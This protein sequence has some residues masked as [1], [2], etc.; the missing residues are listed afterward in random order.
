MN[1]NRYG[2]PPEIESSAGRFSL[3][4]FKY[5][6]RFFFIQLEQHENVPFNIR[7]KYGQDE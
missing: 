4:L 7:S 1:A 6:V 5:A 3:L 2:L